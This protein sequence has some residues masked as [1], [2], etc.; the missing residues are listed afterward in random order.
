MILRK[1]I[2]EIAKREGV[3]PDTVDK[4]WV[5]GHFLVELFRADW[6]QKYLVFKG[7]TCLKK[8]YFKDY[9][10][11]EDLDFT[12]INP[13]FDVSKT[14]IQ[15]I[16]DNITKNIGI[17]FSP[18]DY[19]SLESV[20]KPV[21]YQSRVNFWGA[22]HQRNQQPPPCTR[23]MTSI[24]IEIIHYEQLVS[25][26][27]QRILFDVFSDSGNFSDVKIPC[28]SIHEIIAE[29]F[30][31]LLQR[32][33]SAPR[34]YYDLWNLLRLENIEWET[35]LGILEQKLKFKNIQ[36]NGYEDFFTDQK[37]N[38]VKS[39]WNNSLKGHLPVGKLPDVECVLS[40]LQQ[41]C[42][43]VKWF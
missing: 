28:Y 13:Q 29:K 10:F 26:P 12:L 19:K 20:N 36:W 22:N 5:L 40:E 21:G 9:R 11:S 33:Y 32:S 37:L 16:C 39:E 23:W 31:A 18:I 34:D 30:R 35:I 41:K 3:T 4:N 43:S 24:K 27:E 6:A 7:G 17:L 8:C 1:E 14:L 2:S 42:S 38:S 25:P 15:A